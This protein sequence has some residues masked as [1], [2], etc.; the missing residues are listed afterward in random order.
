MEKVI[1]FIVEN[2]ELLI[3][4]AA[5][6]LDLILFLVGVFRKKV[7]PSVAEVVTKIPYF[8]SLAEDK[9]GSGQGLKKK[10]FV[11]EEACKLYEKMTDIYP[12]LR[13]AIRKVFSKAVEE[14]LE[15]P[16]KKGK[17]L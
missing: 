2:S 10:E 9:F 13:S 17:I 15:T 3:L 16:Q 5:C 11:V 12:N 7:N 8:V 14:V 4:L 1:D 6:L